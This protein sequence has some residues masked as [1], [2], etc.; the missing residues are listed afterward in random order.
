VKFRRY[1]RSCKAPG[2]P[3][4]DWIFLNSVAT[5]PVYRNGKAFKKGKPE[6]LPVQNNSILLSGEKHR[7]VKSRT[8]YFFL[9]SE[10][11]H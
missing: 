6:D 3:Y 10:S 11:S 5:V 7:D 8:F 4:A 9:F 2:P 1:P